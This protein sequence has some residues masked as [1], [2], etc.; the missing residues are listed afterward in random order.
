MAKA[1]KSRWAIVGVL[2]VILAAGYFFVDQARRDKARA[3]AQASAPAGIPVTVGVAAAQ[4]MPI[5]ARGIGTVQAYKMVTVKSRVDGQIVKVSF[6]EGQEVKAGDPLFQID[7]RPFQASLDQAM[8]IKQRDE[9]QLAG[10]AADL[11]RYGKL[12]GQGYQSRQ[13]YDQQKATVDSLKGSLAADAAAIETAK[14]NPGFADIRAPID[15]RTG[16]RQVDPGN[17]IQA[18]QNTALVTITQVKPIFVN[19]TVPQDQTD[20]IRTNQARGALTVVAYGSDD[21]TELARGSVTLIENQIDSATGT[22]RLKG[23]FANTHERLWPGEFVN[24]RLILSTRKG[25][26][27]VPQRTV[28]QGANDSYVYA[29]KADSTVERRTVQVAA[30][31]DGVAAIEKGLALGEKVVIDG[32]YRLTNGARIKVDT[33]KPDP[34]PATPNEPL[35]AHSKD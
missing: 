5:Y 23:T 30:T 28:M 13:S 22:L 16:S 6:D 17:L 24:V 11:E 7:P 15:G 2:L 29:V 35:T 33:A 31:Q 4:D 10:A 8:A 27:T 26:V 14:L 18:G 12:I 21:K 25:A 1:R 34:P 19:F 9:A 32:Q 20:T 3:A